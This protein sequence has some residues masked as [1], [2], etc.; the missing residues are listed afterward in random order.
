MSFDANRVS[1]LIHNIQVSKTP[2]ADIESILKRLGRD[3]ELESIRSDLDFCGNGNL[4]K[5]LLLAFA[6]GH[7]QA[8]HQASE[9]V[10][11]E[12]NKA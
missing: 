2:L 6:E 8:R 12:G 11:F 4:N 5:V 10:I 9:I 7:K 3:H 1:G